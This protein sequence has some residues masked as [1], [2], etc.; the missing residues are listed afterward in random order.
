M[1]I[2]YKRFHLVSRNRDGICKCRKEMSDRRL[3]ICS[4]LW[5]HD[6]DPA[7]PVAIAIQYALHMK[8]SLH[9]VQMYIHTI[10]TPQDIL[11]E[12]PIHCTLVHNISGDSRAA[13]AADTG[14]RHDD[15]L[16]S[17]LRSRTPLLGPLKH[18]LSVRADLG[19][20]QLG[21]K[22]YTMAYYS[23]LW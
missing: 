10:P 19:S 22:S 23:I 2:V 20:L 11:Q 12:P 3:V 6:R 1:P 8:C 13:R 17:T 4:E 14:S 16:A 7:K 9:V 5:L 15:H 21:P 18:F